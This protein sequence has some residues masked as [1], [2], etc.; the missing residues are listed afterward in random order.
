[1]TLRMADRPRSEQLLMKQMRERK[2][3]DMARKLAAEL[4]DHAWLDL[5]SAT[6]GRYESIARALL[7]IA[8][9]SRTATRANASRT[10]EQRS[11]ISRKANAARTPEQRSEAS[12]RA[13]AKRKAARLQVGG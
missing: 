10:P 6:R 7:K 8:E 3:H 11:E 2:V 13:N 4:A 12:R 9:G 1:M 5:T